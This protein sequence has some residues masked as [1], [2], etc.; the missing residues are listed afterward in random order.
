VF[1]D[2]NNGWASGSFGTI[3]HTN[4][5]GK[6]WEAQATNTQEHM[7]DIQFIDQERGWVVGPWGT[8][9]HTS[10]GGKK[11]DSQSIGEDITLNCL[12][13]ID[14]QEGWIGG[15]WGTILHTTNGGKEWVKRDSSLETSLFGIYF[16]DA[17]HGWA[18]GMLGKLIFTNDAGETW[19]Q[20]DS[21]TGNALLDAE[22]AG[23]TLWS[24]GS[25]GAL[26]VI[27]IGQGGLQNTVKPANTNQWL[28]SIS[29]LP[30]DHRYGFIVGARG[31]ILYTQDGGGNW[32][33]KGFVLG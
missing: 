28:S 10:N 26:V 25:K 2:K 31:T 18:A 21:G 9:L 14:S 30:T 24:V 22:V 27:S 7:L 15:E 6:I 20:V 4:D 11:W 13:F 3:L 5:G 32:V 29:F 1:L 19:Q 23:N 12:Y 16:T 17:Q 8:V 33:H